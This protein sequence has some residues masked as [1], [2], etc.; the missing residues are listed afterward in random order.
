MRRFLIFGI[1]F[2][3]W[4]RASA[5]A[6]DAGHSAL[7]RGIRAALVNATESY[8]LSTSD[9]ELFAPRFPWDA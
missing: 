3:N 7:E 8:R 4:C 6:P 9:T 5:A 1:A 2:S